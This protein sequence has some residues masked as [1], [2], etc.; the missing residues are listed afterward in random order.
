VTAD[1]A[2]VVMRECGNQACRIV[3][4]RVVVISVLV[5]VMIAR[6]IRCMLVV[7][8]AMMSTALMGMV[9]Q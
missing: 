6:F 9:V 7:I 1:R 3:F 8:A 5:I 4:V 2:I